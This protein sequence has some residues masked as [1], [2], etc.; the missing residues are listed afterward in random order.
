MPY[1]THAALLL[2]SC[3]PR[4]LASASAARRASYGLAYSGFN[5]SCP[6]GGGANLALGPLPPLNEPQTPVKSG[7]FFAD[8]AITNGSRVLRPSV[9]YK[10]FFRF[11]AAISGARDQVHFQL[12]FHWA[13]WPCSRIRRIARSSAG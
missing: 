9:A 11:I 4:L 1:G 12:L 5:S 6:A 7:G 3:S 8:C 2:A 13:A 10:V